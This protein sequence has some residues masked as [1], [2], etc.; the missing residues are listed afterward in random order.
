MDIAKTRVIALAL[1]THH[2]LGPFDAWWKRSRSIR[3]RTETLVVKHPCF[4]S[5]VWH[6][7]MYPE[8][9]KKVILLLLLAF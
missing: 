3:E 8:C 1:L 4:D 5:V 7:G 6:L 9:P 2:L